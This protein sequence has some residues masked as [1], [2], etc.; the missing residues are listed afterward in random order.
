[1]SI[2]R[3]IR[4]AAYKENLAGIKIRITAIQNYLRNLHW[5]DLPLTK[6]HHNR[7][8]KYN[9]S[10]PKDL[11]KSYLELEQM[12]AS[13]D[14]DLELGPYNFYHYAV[15]GDTSERFNTIDIS[16]KVEDSNNRIHVPAAGIAMNLRNLGLGIKIYK[17]I[18]ADLGYITS[19]ESDASGRV[20]NSLSSDLVWH[21]LS[22]DPEVYVQAN[23]TRI[24]AVLNRDRERFTDI[25]ADYLRQ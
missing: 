23:E 8:T 19:T 24:I 4:A 1:M 9:F 12:V 13:V 16:A 15:Y 10:F 22:L 18:M 2:E 14:N 25:I 5:S 21:S 3:L 11:R 20:K 17:F 7:E 6:I